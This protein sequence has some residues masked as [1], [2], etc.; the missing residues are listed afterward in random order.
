[1]DFRNIHNLLVDLSW[2]QQRLGV[3]ATENETGSGSPQIPKHMG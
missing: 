1:L 3:L 2:Q